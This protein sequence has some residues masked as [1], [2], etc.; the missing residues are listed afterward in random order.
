MT[1]QIGGQACHGMYIDAKSVGKLPLPL[2][3]RSYGP[4]P[5]IGPGIK[6]IALAVCLSNKIMKIFLF[7]FLHLFRLTLYL[8]GL[9]TDIIRGFLKI[10]RSCFIDLA[11][12]NLFWALIKIESSSV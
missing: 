11:G 7:I 5:W 9:P 3:L 10:R 6:G 8:S 4:S 1:L 12:L 2:S